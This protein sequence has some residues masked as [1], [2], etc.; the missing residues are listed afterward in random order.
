MILDKHQLK[1]IQDRYNE[2]GRL[3]FC[4]V[5]NKFLEEACTGGEW[6]SGYGICGNRECSIFCLKF[7][8]NESR[9]GQ[10]LINLTDI[11]ENNT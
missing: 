2:V 9:T 5:C 1:T 6:A 11:Y 4:P 8:A 7:K 10:V 3:L